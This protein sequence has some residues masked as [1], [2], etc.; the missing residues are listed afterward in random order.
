MSKRTKIW[1]IIAACLILVGCIAFGGVIAVLK[2]DFTKLSTVRYETNLHEINESYQNISII[3]DTADVEFVPSV[4]SNTSV[5]CYEQQ[6][7]RHTVRVENGSLVIELVDLR[8]WYEYIGISFANPKITV[9]ISEGEYGALSIKSSTGKVEIPRDFR[10]ESIDISESTGNVTSYACTSDYIK[11]KTSTGDIRVEGISAGALDLSASTGKVSLA[12]VTCEENVKINVST[13]RTNVTNVKCQ[14]IISTGSTGG[15]T[16]E[17]AIAA[18][19]FSVE[20]STGSVKLDA[21]DAAEIYIKTDT[22]NVTGSLLSDKIFMVRSDTGSIEVPK[23]VTGGICEIT[24][25][26]G[27]IKV[28]IKDR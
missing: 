8:K 10:F 21:C 11:I 13:G 25:D 14:N 23:T 4:N 7:S 19:R 15:I 22:G 17:N 1:L 18:E 9:Y 6:K 26:T 12:D 5:V 28:N 2:W 3:T 27:D 24:T 16:F 20:R